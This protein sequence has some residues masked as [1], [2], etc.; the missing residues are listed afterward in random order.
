MNGAVLLLLYGGSYQGSPAPSYPIFR[1][2]L[3]VAA[4]MA[5]VVDARAVSV[6]PSRAVTVSDPLSVS[7]LATPRRTD[8]D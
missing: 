2:A 1:G 6:M 4:R 7:V 5:S 3:P 8:V